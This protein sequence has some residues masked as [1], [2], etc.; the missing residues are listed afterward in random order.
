MPCSC[1]DRKLDF[2][3]PLTLGSVAIIPVQ[4]LNVVWVH[5]TM[6]GSLQ[7]TRLELRPQQKYVCLVR[8][9]QR[10]GGKKE[11]ILGKESF[12]ANGSTLH[13]AVVASVGQPP[14]KRRKKGAT[15]QVSC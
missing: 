14:K 4:P 15:E 1:L 11:L 12:C 8:K 13:S 5:L 9:K 10:N 3:K 6:V 7:E 2:R